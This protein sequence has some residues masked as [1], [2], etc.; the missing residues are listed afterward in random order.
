MYSETQNLIWYNYTNTV[1]NPVAYCNYTGCIHNLICS[2]TCTGN[3][4]DGTLN[5]TYSSSGMVCVTPCT[6]PEFNLTK[7]LSICMNTN[8]TPSIIALF[9][10]NNYSCFN[11]SQNLSSFYSTNHSIWNATAG[12]Y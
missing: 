8:C 12:V 1:F 10:S 9:S 2:T 4:C 3:L 6:Y 7:N 5:A 11:S